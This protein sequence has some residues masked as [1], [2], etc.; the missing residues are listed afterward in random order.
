MLQ[1]E[2]LIVA[3]LEERLAALTPAPGVLTAPDLAGV[4]EE[5]Q[6]APAVY[7]VYGGHQIS[8]EQAEGSIVELQ[9][10]WHTV[11]V[12]RNVRTVRT[13]ADVRADAGPIMGAVFRALTGWRPSND[14]RKLRPIN[15]PR[16]GYSKGYGYFP[17]SWTVK[18]QMRGD[19]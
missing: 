12:V 5:Q 18:L 19:M 8:Q 15:S 11:V 3:R 6:K 13:G 2:P 7:V 17:L 4:A 1:V 14:M 9:Q 16:A 10:T